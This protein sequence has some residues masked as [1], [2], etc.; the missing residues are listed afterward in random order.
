M[1]LVSI[2]LTVLFITVFCILYADHHGYLYF[3]GR[4]QTLSI[5][6]VR[7]L[8]YTVILG[9]VLMIVTGGLL[10]KDAWGEFIDH[11]PFYVKM[12]FV[13]GLIANSF[14]IGKLMHLATIKTF[15]SLS[16]RERSMLIFSGTTS[17]LCWIGA[18]SIGF[19]FL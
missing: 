13:L 4:K 6:L 9:L 10:F 14:L 7:R 8:H 16:Y 12:F 5:G 3:R 18:A 11:P 19:L 15:S 1:E 17:A 2:H